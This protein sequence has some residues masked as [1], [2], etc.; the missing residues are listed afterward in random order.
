M[1]MGM[2]MGGGMGMGMDFERPMREFNLVN[3]VQEATEIENWYE[4]G[5]E[6]TIVPYEGKK[7]VV[8]TTPE[9]HKKVGELLA[10]MRKALGQ[11]VAIEARFL[12]V[13][14]NFLEDVGI[15]FEFAFDPGMDWTRIAIRQGHSE[16]TRPGGTKVPGSFGGGSGSLGS[17]LGLELGGP[18]PGTPFKYQIDDLQADLLLRAV[19]AHKD[20]KSLAAPKVTVLSGES[21]MISVETNT[22]IA[23]PPDISTGIIAPGLSGTTTTESIIP[24]FEPIISGTNLNITPIITQDKK[25]VLLNITT[26][27]QDFLGMKSNSVTTP[28]PGG[29]VVTYEQQL[30]ET[31]FSQVYTRVSVPDSGTLLL[32]G[33]K[34]S[35]EV[36]MEIGVPILSKIPVIGRLFRNRSVVKDQKILLILVKPTIILQEER[37]AEASAALEGGY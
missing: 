4:G 17:S 3:I 13:S 36:E 11:Q 12:I 19:Q 8:K 21:A 28:L 31:E 15:D 34:I 24:R 27:L 5:G 32:G 2:G 22:V 14:E 10:D 37:D 25:H 35:Q 23:L 7:L 6:G 16:A 20:S 26:S 30:P 29:E 9:I 33:Q 18:A 1:G